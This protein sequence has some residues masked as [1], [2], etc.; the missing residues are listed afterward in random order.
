M[1]A[2]DRYAATHQP[3]LAAELIVANADPY[4]TVPD[5][6]MGGLSPEESKDLE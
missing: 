2:E 4:A 3:R 1:P 5:W 6:Q